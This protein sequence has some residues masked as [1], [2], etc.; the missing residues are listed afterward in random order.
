VQAVADAFR[1]VEQQSGLLG[2][3]VIDYEAS[4]A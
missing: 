2:P 4:N 1:A 3:P